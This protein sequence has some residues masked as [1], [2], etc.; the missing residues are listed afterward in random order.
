MKIMRIIELHMRIQQ[1]I[2]LKEFNASVMKIMKK[3]EFHMRINKIMKIK[4]N[5]IENQ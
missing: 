4:T 2:K 5:Q 1:I 3:F